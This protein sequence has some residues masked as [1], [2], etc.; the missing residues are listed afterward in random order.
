MG[1]EEYYERKSLLCQYMEYDEKSGEWLPID[2]EAA[3]KTLARQE[4][5]KQHIDK[6]EKKAVELDAYSDGVLFRILMTDFK[7]YAQNWSKSPFIAH[8]IHNRVNRERF[9]YMKKLKARV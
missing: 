3:Y 2:K 6:L 8:K 7:K 5:E 9:S 1:C 4:Q